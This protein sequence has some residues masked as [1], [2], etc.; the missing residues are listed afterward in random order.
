M[1]T[2]TVTAAIA[3]APRRCQAAYIVPTL[4]RDEVLSDLRA[5]RNHWRL[6]Q[7]EAELELTM[8][9]AGGASARAIV[10][11]G[12]TCADIGALAE[13]YRAQIAELDG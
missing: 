6:A 3:G 4:T 1:T 2:T 10:L 13:S 11:A 9:R 5:L 8:L 12:A 7:L